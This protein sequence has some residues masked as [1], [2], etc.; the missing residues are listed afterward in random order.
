MPRNGDGCERDGVTYQDVYDCQCA[1]TANN[2]AASVPVTYPNH[3]AWSDTHS[4]GHSGDRGP[5]VAVLPASGEPRGVAGRRDV[6]G[7][8]FFWTG[9]F[10]QER[11]VDG[12]GTCQQL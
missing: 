6:E 9:S 4:I 8:V 1:G 7:A 12:Y 5:P 3:C 10:L 2:D 11:D